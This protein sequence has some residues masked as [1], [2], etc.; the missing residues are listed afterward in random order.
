[1]YNIFWK[2]NENNNINKSYNWWGPFNGWVFFFFIYI[3]GLLGKRLYELKC[4]FG[5][6]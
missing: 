6:G 1:M 3:F 2:K 4:I 5:S